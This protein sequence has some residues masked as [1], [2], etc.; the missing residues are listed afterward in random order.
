VEEK[1]GPKLPY[2]KEEEKV[3]M[4]ICHAWGSKANLLFL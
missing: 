2:P 4:T 3:E 1:N